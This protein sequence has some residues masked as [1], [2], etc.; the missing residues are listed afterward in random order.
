MVM[1]E[2]IQTSSLEKI[3]PETFCDAK[4][5]RML[6]GLKGERISYQIAYRDAKKQ[7]YAYKIKSD[8]K[9]HLQVF[10]VVNVNVSLPAPDDAKD[11]TNYISKKKGMYPDILYPAKKNEVLAESK[12]KSLWIMTDSSVPSGE[13]EIEITFSD[14]IEKHSTKFEVIILPEKLPDSG[15]IFTQWFYCDCIAKY[16]HTKVFSPRHWELIEKFI[17]M[18]A[19][20][21]MNMILTP[22]FT[23]PL[24][25]E[26]G[27]ERPT[28]QLVGIKKTDSGYVFDFANLKKWIKLCKKHGIDHFEMAHLFTQWGAKATPKIIAEVRGK[29]K[30]IFGWDT[31][32]DDDSY[33]EFLSQFLPALAECLEKEGVSQ[34][35]VF[36]ISDEPQ[37][38]EGYLKAK[39]MVS[40]YLKGFKIV[41][42][43]SD[44]EF[45]QQ[46]IVKYPYVATNY[47]E[48]FI[49]NT[50]N[51]MVYYCCA[52]GNKVSNRFIA[53]PSCRN[54]CIASQFYKFKVKSFL[55]WGYNF[56]FTNLSKAEVDPFEDTTAGGAYPGGDSFSVY[57]GKDGPIPSIRLFVFYEALC[58]LRAMKLL[59]KYIGY[60]RTLKL[61]E[62]ITGEVSFDRC[63]ED[64]EIV[65]TLREKINE[66]IEK[67]IKK[68]QK[69]WDV[70]IKL[71]S[72]SL[73][74]GDN[75]IIE[76]EK[77]AKKK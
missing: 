48:P 24:D 32:A 6:S 28:V 10:D 69:N 71:V 72:K 20:N 61:I 18:A 27:G 1:L 45:Y 63:P 39:K 49:G 23:P 33:K 77:P 40:K 34:N 31:N 64:P 22:I 56:Y 11:D 47:V 5:C 7:S 35:T 41:D 43:L 60:K 75:W 66:E 44:F 25:T 30:R 8:I 67:H 12:F 37:E 62:D 13:H 51:L 26:I 74:G 59:E 17:A 9:K 70:D 29:K 2:T 14:G 53:M 42:A 52:Q 46:G 21:G 68:E 57:P 3:M 65:L 38:T 73:T 16:Y 58:D 76:A 54:R 55:Q 36:H 19:D 15:L 50:K 4:E